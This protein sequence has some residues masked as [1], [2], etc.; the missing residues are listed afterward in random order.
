MYF[1]TGKKIKMTLN[2]EKVLTP[3]RKFDNGLDFRYTN[4]VR[5]ILNIAGSNIIQRLAEFYEKTS[6]LEKEYSSDA[7]HLCLAF[8]KAD[9]EDWERKAIR[10]SLRE[11]LKEIGF[12][13]SKVSSLIGASEFIYRLKLEH[14]NASNLHNYKQEQKRIKDILDLLDS[15]PISSKYI[16]SRMHPYGLKLAVERSKKRE[17]NKTT[18]TFDLIPITRRELEKIQRDNPLNDLETRGRRSNNT[19]TQGDSRNL[20][21][22]ALTSSHGETYEIPVIDELFVVHKDSTDIEHETVLPTQEELIRALRVIVKQIDLDKVLVDD[23]LQS[24][25]GPIQNQLKTLT[26]LAIS[27]TQI[28]NIL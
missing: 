23:A 14:S 19:T 15:L 21:D 28:P 26:H 1:L 17:W 4:H 10:F 20:I 5:N 7:L 25:L 22:T 9:M 16:L 18:D 2:I 6:E 12:K 13:P 27:I 11:L 8:Y 24:Q 3:K